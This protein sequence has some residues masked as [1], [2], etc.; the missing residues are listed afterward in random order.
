MTVTPRCWVY[1]GQQD[2][3]VPWDSLVLYL[4]SVR[5]GHLP[6]APLCTSLPWRTWWVSQRS[7]VPEPQGRHGPVA[8][9]RL[10]PPKCAGLTW[11]PAAARCLW[12]GRQKCG[13]WEQP[14]LAPEELTY[15]QG[16]SCVVSRQG[17]SGQVTFLG[18]LQAASRSQ[19]ARAQC[20]RGWVG[21]DEVSHPVLPGLRMRIVV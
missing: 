2:Q 10:P 17:L 9:C 5:E 13:G 15:L 1:C 4:V 12:W 20:S 7:G 6:S 18:K 3:T 19:A 21:A 8:Q 16:N 11:A 14:T